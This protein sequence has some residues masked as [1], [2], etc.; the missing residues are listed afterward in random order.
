MNII[1]DALN[2][3]E[4]FVLITTEKIKIQVAKWREC[5]PDITPHYAV[6]CNNNTTILKILA[7]L[8]VNFDCASI[9]EIKQ[10]IELVNDP[11]RIIYANTC[12]SKKSLEYAKKVGVKLMT[13]DSTHELE[14]IHKIIPDAKLV[15]R[16]KS[17]ESDS[18]LKFN[19][20]FGVDKEDYRN[21]ISKCKELELN[22]VGISFHVGSK[23]N[24]ADQYI[25][26]IKECRSIFDIA[27]KEYHYGIS[28][29]DIGGG[30]PI[31][32]DD[33]QKYRFEKMAAK[34]NETIKQEFSNITVIA[35]PGRYMVGNS[36]QL[37]MRIIGKKE[38]I[39]NEEKIEY[40]AND[41]VYSTL[42]NTIFD[43][44]IISISVTRDI[45]PEEDLYDSDIWGHTCDSMDILVKSIQ[46]PELD[47]DDWIYA[48]NVGAYTISSASTFNGFNHTKLIFV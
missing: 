35:E 5:L 22:L 9:N 42:N 1:D 28:L 30:F 20:K 13:F 39:T 38:S 4:A 27:T 47:I 37:F 41:S 8:D 48:N 15:I 29:L 44:E 25:E 40:T 12:K 34:I 6:K 3:E 36:H 26:T 2:E 18:K 33:F 19:S 17:D 21:V 11:D 16:I 24:S 14:K 43:N 23:A 10:I 32:K 45:S 31:I 46:I 7:D